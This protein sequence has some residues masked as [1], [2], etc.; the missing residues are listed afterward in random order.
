MLNF[1]LKKT[2]VKNNLLLQLIVEDGTIQQQNNN[3]QWFLFH[4]KIL[5]S[6]LKN[7]Q[8]FSRS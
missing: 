5:K 1:A 7:G 6:N 8:D 3:M 2:M 4:Y